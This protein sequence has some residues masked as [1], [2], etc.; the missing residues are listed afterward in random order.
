MLYLLSYLLSKGTGGE[1]K[2]DTAVVHW[3]DIP[4]LQFA[5]RMNEIRFQVVPLFDMV[6]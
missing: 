2:N 4:E 1:M 3:L 6:R 5:A